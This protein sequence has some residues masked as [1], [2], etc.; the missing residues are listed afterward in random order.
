MC[1]GAPNNYHPMGLH[2]VYAYP[3]AILV[4]LRATLPFLI[5]ISLILQFSALSSILPI[6]YNGDSR[7]ESV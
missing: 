3:P 7:S 2:L 4:P 5:L 6:S 1:I